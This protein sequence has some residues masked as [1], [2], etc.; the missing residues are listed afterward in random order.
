MGVHESLEAIPVDMLINLTALLDDAKCYDLVR[1]TRWP[2]G[3]RCP[4]CASTD[5]VR[6]GH[7]ETQPARQ[8]Y[9]CHGCKARFDDLS[10]TVLAGHH[11]PLKTWILCLYLMGLNLSNRQIAQELNLHESDAQEMTTHLRTGIAA[12]AE[13]AVLS[14]EV[15]IDEVYV[16]AGHKG[17]P[18][19][20]QKKAAKGGA[21]G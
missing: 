18:A 4:K 13:P 20:V 5:A 3:L 17:N 10:D 6:N 1:K 7:D 15:E 2:Q 8:R 12:K 11:Q 19:A 9:L 21:T 14:G 16:V